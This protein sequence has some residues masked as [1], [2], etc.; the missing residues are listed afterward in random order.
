MKVI[1]CLCFGL[2]AGTLGVYGQLRLDTL[3]SPTKRVLGWKELPPGTLA[4]KAG[5]SVRIMQP[6]HMPCV[7][8]NLALLQRMPV[9]LMKSTDPMPNGAQASG[10]EQPPGDEQP[11]RGEQPPDWER[12]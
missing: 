6:D 2:I 5:R 12:P 10:G 11:P 7:V 1:L 9:I 8:A 3:P 4:I